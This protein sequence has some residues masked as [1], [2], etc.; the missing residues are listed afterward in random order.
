M[1]GEDYSSSS[2]NGGSL[3]SSNKLSINGFFKYVFNFDDN[4]KSLIYNII[5]Y[6][7]IGIIPSFL[8]LKGIKHYIPEDDDT[9]GTIEITIEV[10]LQLFLIFF[11]ILIIDRMIR[12]FPTFSGV[13]YQ[14]SNTINIILPLLIILIT[15]QTKLGSKI[16]ILGDRIMDIINNNNN[17]HV[18]ISN[19]GSV[20]ISQPIVTPNI[21][22]VSRAD[23][24]DNTLIAQPPSQIPAQNNVSMIDALP[25]MQQ[26]SIQQNSG[27]NNY[28]NQAITNSFMETMEPMAANGALGGAFGSSF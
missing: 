5:Q 9:K 21:H 17:P 4:S 20:K 27:L 3:D 8:V 1:E 25:N 26:N 22:Q 14:K 23:T 15:M 2:L 16:N 28:Q 13:D 7:L 12:Y 24:L 10:L 19:H 6:I 18:G 11:S